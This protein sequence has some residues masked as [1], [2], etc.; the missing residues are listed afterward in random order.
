MKKSITFMFAAMMLLYALSC[1]ASELLEVITPGHKAKLTHQVI[2]ENSLL[3]SVKDS[4]NNPIKGLKLEDFVIKSG[5]REAQIQSIEAGRNDWSEIAPKPAFFCNPH[6][7]VTR[8]RYM[9]TSGHHLFR[10]SEPCAR[11]SQFL[12]REPG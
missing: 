1:P 10:G 11:G 9:G 2:D 8:C 7:I 4:Q 6:R 12:E 3:V 5:K